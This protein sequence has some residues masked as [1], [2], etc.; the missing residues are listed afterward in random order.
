M[1]IIGQYTYTLLICILIITGCNNSSKKDLLINSWKLT[2]TSDK[3]PDDKKVEL[4]KNAMLSFDKDGSFTLA[5]MGGT[6]TGTWMISD[7]AKQLTLKDA[8]GSTHENL[9]LELTKN[10]L[11]IKDLA[12]GSTLTASAN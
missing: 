12:T 6:Q 9:I 4:L 3:I 1:K 7:D 2:G 5:G 11:S 8:N 10:S